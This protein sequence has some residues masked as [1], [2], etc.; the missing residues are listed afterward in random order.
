MEARTSEYSKE[1]LN[2]FYFSIIIIITFFSLLQN[3]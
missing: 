2:H 1:T 3:Q